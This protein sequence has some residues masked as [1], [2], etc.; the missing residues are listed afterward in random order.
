MHSFYVNLPICALAMAVLI[1]FLR[2]PP[3]NNRLT[4]HQRLVQLDP[5]G[6][7]FFMPGIIYLL[8]AL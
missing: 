8:L 6:N 4:L 2:L 3:V 5:L 7:L 1:L